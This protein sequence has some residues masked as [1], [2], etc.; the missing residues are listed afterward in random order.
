V[1]THHHLDTDPRVSRSRPR[2][3][4]ASRT[5]TNRGRLWIARFAGPKPIA[6]IRASSRP[7]PRIPCPARS[8]PRYGDLAERPHGSYRDI[9]GTMGLLGP[10]SDSDSRAATKAWLGSIPVPMI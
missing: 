8:R 2:R 10:V 7:S 3:N 4:E 9:V 6:A 1:V 5:I